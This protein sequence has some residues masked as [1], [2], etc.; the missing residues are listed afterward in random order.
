MPMMMAAAAAH[1]CPDRGRSLHRLET[2]AT[3]ALGRVA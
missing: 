3:L 2:I 1:A